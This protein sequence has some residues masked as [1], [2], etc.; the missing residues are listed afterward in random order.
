MTVYNLVFENIDSR[1]AMDHSLG[2]GWRERARSIKDRKISY[3]II[4]LIR[5]FQIAL[6]VTDSSIK[7]HK[8][9]QDIFVW[10]YFFNSPFSNSIICD[11]QKH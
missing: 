9:N 5:R 1:L 2:G 7:R 8:V 4:F 6:F 3:G 10:Y 11:W